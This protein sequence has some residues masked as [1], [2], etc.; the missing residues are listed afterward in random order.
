MGRPAKPVIDGKQQCSTCREWKILSVFGKSNITS[1]GHDSRC[2][3]C[4]NER[5]RRERKSPEYRAKR[6][7]SHN[8]YVKRRK[9]IDPTFKLTRQLRSRLA[10]AVRRQ[11]HKGH[12]GASAVKDVGCSMA[13]LIVHI[14]QQFQP[15]MSWDNYGKWHIDHIKPLSSFDLTDEV[16]CGAACHFSNLQPLW[17]A[18]N[19]RKLN[20][21]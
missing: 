13:N 12:R 18:D 19:I 2:R 21:T 14:E 20:H 10:I 8:E 9:S 1:N 16:Q 15:G 5:L 17:A 4:N 6:N 3:L 7:R 11:L